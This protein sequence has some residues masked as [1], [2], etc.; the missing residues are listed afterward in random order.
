MG[1]DIDPRV[2][3]WDFWNSSKES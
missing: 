2:W 3:L 1:V